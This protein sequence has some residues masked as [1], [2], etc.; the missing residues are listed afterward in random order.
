LF[1]EDGVP[2]SLRS[3]KAMDEIKG[4]TFNATHIAKPP[5]IGRQIAHAIYGSLTPATASR[6][7][8]RFSGGG[9]E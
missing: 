2:S 8:T 7:E 4:A 6:R 3:E 9:S 5:G 1:G